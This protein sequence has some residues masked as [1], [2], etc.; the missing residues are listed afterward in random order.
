MRRGGVKPDFDAPQGALWQLE[1][2]CSLVFSHI[3][4]RSSSR[5]FSCYRSG[6]EQP[7][8]R[9]SSQPMQAHILIACSVVHT[10]DI[11]L[12]STVNVFV[13]SPDTRSERRFDLGLT[14]GQLKVSPTLPRYAAIVTF[15][16]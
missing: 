7:N 5:I 1:L 13:R 12:R 10:A 6:T 3:L 4:S 11:L 9:P 15:C 2:S 14:I 8:M 16:A